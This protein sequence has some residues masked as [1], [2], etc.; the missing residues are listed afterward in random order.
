[1]ILFGYAAPP[2]DVGDVMHD[3]YYGFQA[4]IQ[5]L[6][7]MPFVLLGIGLSFVLSRSA[8][9]SAGRRQGM[10]WV[11]FVGAVAIYIG[12]NVL[13]TWLSFWN[14]MPRRYP[15]EGEM[16]SLEALARGAYGAMTLG[17]AVVAIALLYFLWTLFKGRIAKSRL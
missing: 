4:I 1:L 8:D 14:D 12:V 11:A 16:T 9:K 10:A 2:T 15:S 17:I 7:T 6:K 5:F 3:L 13:T